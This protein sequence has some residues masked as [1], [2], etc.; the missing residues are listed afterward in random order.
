MRIN[1]LFRLA[2]I[3]VIAVGAVIATVA[4]TDTSQPQVVMAAKKKVKVKLTSTVFYPDS[5][6]KAYVTGKTTPKAKVKAGLLGYVKVGKSGTFKLKVKAKAKDKKVTI[7][8]KLSGHKTTKKKVTIKAK[9]SVDPKVQAELKTINETIATRLKED[10]GFADGTL[11]ENGNPTKN[12]TP[13]EAFTWATYIDS[14]TIDA[15]HLVTAQAK[16]AAMSLPKDDQKA[17]AEH[18][19]KLALATLAELDKASEQELT[20]KL[21]TSL[22]VGNRFISHY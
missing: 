6:N 22:K 21:P 12:G 18:S 14:I 3:A 4:T 16:T 17:L 13:N 9:G 5:S 15:D 20:S 10:Q 1:K 19:G 7:T 8:A 11:D 2:A